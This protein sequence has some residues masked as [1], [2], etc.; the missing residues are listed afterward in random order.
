MTTTPTTRP[1]EILDAAHRDI[2]DMLGQMRQL[3]DYVK[4]SD[5][6]DHARALARKVHLF[7]STTAL[8]HHLDEEHHIFPA[9]LRTADE[10]LSHTLA[11]LQQD[12]AWLEANWMEL[13]PQLDSLARG[14]NWHDLDEVKH[15]LDLFTG[16]YEDHVTLEESLIYPKARARMNP[17]DFATM[18]REMAARRAQVRSQSSR[19]TQ[20]A[21]GAA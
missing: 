12:H 20:P 11:Q 5:V 17:G 14:Y 4:V 10:T 9:L 13:A 1:M 15:A 21:A 19:R 7:F 16:L 6:D 2:A 8:Q 3:L 18:S